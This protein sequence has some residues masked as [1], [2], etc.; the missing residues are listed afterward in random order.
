MVLAA[1]AQHT[2]R[3]RLGTNTLITPFYEPGSL[4]Q[5]L[6]TLDILSN[7]RLDLAFGS[8]SIGIEFETFRRSA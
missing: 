5:D 1:V 4:S 3:I 6:A 7:E 8:G 2:S